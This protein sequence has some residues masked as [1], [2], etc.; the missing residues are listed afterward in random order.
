M[1]EVPAHVPADRVYPFD[2]HNDPLIS[3]DI[4]DGLLRLRQDAPPIFWTPAHGGHWIVSDTDLMVSVL[5]TP[6]IYSS[7]QLQIPPREDAPRMIPESLDPPE[8]LL[9]RR[10]MMEYFEKSRIA[11]LQARVNFWT[12]TLL[13]D[14]EGKA[15]CDFVEVVASRL[16]VYV[17]MEFAG[18]PL[19]RADDF[20]SLVDGMFRSSDPA[21]RQNYA[22]QIM[23][24]LQ[25]L[26][27]ARMAEPKDD[28]LSKLI[29]AD[30][31]GRKLTFEELM[32][33][34]FLLF[35]AG[36][37]TVTNAMTF[38]IRHLARDGALRARLRD[39]PDRIPDA[40]EELL[41]RYTFPTLPR[42]VT[43]DTELGGV[44]L[45]AGDMILCL[46]A[47]AGL[48]ETLN[49]DALSVDLDREKRTHF[50][51]GTGGHTCLGR[52]L[53]KMELETLYRRWL[54]V[55]PDFEIDP[56]RKAAAPR[57]GAVM[58][59]PELWLRLPA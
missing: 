45:K 19:E 12:D 47:L 6:A 44:S 38:G 9:Y 32:S 35:L 41:R 17:F 21:Q 34:G 42:Q 40:V 55:F 57:G 5:K 27:T 1:A 49:P 48:D 53:A 3:E 13:A 23:G 43:Q 15:E 28:I 2:Y 26:I 31:Q 39:N 18:F 54:E 22:M 25:Q 14:L 36:L 51:F 37:D 59:I 33:I 11:H 58:G 10:L 20:R 7:R 8:H 16:P 52:H 56:S 30:F 24:E 46:I 4:H 29:E 50:A